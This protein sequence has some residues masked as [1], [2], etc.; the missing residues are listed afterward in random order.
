LT[1]FGEEIRTVTKIFK[2]SPTSIAY[3]TNNTVI[4]NC[5]VRAH[6]GKYGTCGVYELKC[7]TCQQVYVGHT[8]RDFKTRYEEYINDIRS[9]K[10]KSRYTYTF[11]KKIVNMAPLKKVWIHRKL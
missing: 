1:Y 9:D 6:K 4:Y 3:M 2:K 7:L 11:Y 8:G 5:I 10:D